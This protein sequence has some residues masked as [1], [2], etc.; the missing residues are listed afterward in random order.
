MR[1]DIRC[2]EGRSYRHD[3]Q[4]DDPELE[5][6]IGR[7]PE[8][9][10]KGCRELF[11]ADAEAKIGEKIKTHFEYPPIPVRDHDWCAVT[12]NY[13]GEGSPIGWGRTEEAAIEDLIAE[14]EDRRSV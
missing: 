11:I 1:G 8:C 2:V 6:D 14:I 7:C 12:D 9:E 3:P 13:D 4:H 10:G 5:T